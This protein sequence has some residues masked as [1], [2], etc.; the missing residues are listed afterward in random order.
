MNKEEEKQCRTVITDVLFL[1]RH[2]SQVEKTNT[3]VAFIDQLV[4][5]YKIMEDYDELQATKNRNIKSLANGAGGGCLRC[6]FCI[7]CLSSLVDVMK[8]TMVFMFL[9]FLLCGFLAVGWHVRSW[10]VV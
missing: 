2:L 3:M 5:K 7:P 8:L 4:R 6:C 1:S 9:F 10:F